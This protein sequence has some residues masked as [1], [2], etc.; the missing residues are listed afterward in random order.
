M[1][2]HN[3][4]Y[5]VQLKLYYSVVTTLFKVHLNCDDPMNQTFLFFLNSFY[6]LRAPG[7]RLI[8]QAKEKYAISSGTLKES[9]PDH[10]KEQMSHS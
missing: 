10:Q 8:A 9:F 4:N 3:L 5:N 7:D 2:N 1:N 6:A